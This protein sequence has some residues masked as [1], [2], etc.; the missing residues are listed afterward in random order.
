[1]TS[2]TLTE[3]A[4]QPPDALSK[5]LSLCPPDV[6]PRIWA[7]G[8]RVPKPDH[9]IRMVVCAANRIF[10][11]HD[12][13]QT[14]DFHL[15]LGPRHF[16]PTMHLHIAAMVAAGCGTREGWRSSEQGF[17]DQHGQFMTREEA[18]TVAVAAGQVRYGP[19]LSGGKLD[20]SDLY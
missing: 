14:G 11:Y 20:S 4:G 10:C 8:K 5:H 3:F 17:I 12:A 1:M 13:G 9:P 18:W 7:E 15:V 2:P 16:S 19:H 6:D